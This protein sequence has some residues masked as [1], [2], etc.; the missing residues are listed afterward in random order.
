[1]D[2]DG[3]ATRWGSFAVTGTFDGTTLRATG[4]VP[5]ALY[6]TIAEPSPRPMAPPDLTAAQWA[7]VESGIRRL[8]GLL[9]TGREGDAG[10]LLVDVVYD[11]GML[12]AW[13][14]ASFGAGAVVVTSALR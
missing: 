2:G 4:A 10:P 3:P 7:D 14:D 9:T 12:Q 11:D 1:V 5:L 8:P 13:A 6:D